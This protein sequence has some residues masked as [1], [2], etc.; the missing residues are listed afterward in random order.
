[1]SITTF[2]HGYLDCPDVAPTTANNNAPAAYFGRTFLVTSR[3]VRDKNTNQDVESETR[4]YQF[5]QLPSTNTPDALPELSKRTIVRSGRSYTTRFSYDG[6]IYGDYHR[7]SRIVETGESSRT[8][9]LTYKHIGSALTSSR[10]IA[11]LKKTETVTATGD[12]TTYSRSWE[13]DPLDLGFRTQDN[14]YGIIT[15]FTNDAFGNVA[16][17]TR[18]THTTGL[19]YAWGTPDGIQ[20]PAYTIKRVI[21]LDGTVAE[22][23]R[24]YG[25]GHPRTTRYSYDDLSRVRKVSPPASNEITTTYDPSGTSVTVARERAF[26]TTTVDGF[27]RPIA[28]VDTAGIQTLTEYDAEGRKIHEGYPFDDRE[29]HTE[30]V[31]DP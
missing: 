18:N 30:I 22:E 26:T 4:C 20:T 16:A 29:I 1:T 8:T 28:T 12:S 10:F 9:T 13:Y 21:N 25:A 15:T 6:P 7:P 31:Y 14:V 27:G 3:V 24:G 2:Q 11:G 17:I 5:V 23:T 19:T